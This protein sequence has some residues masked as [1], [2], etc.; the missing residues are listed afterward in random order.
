MTG[1]LCK[2][3]VS[4]GAFMSLHCSEWKGEIHENTGFSVNHVRLVDYFV[5]TLRISLYLSNV[6]QY[7]QR[8]WDTIALTHPFAS[9]TLSLAQD[10][11][12]TATDVMTIAWSGRGTGQPATATR[13]SRTF[14]TC[15]YEKWFSILNRRALQMLS[16]KGLIIWGTIKYSYQYR[17]GCCCTWSIMEIL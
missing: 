10:W 6:Y 3:I 11:T 8:A 9:S 17:K 13:T 15:N 4:R 1:P 12:L 14:S 7:F 5:Y 2:P 16:G